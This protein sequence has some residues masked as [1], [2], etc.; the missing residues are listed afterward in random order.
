MCLSESCM[1]IICS[2]HDDEVSHCIVL[3][4][5]LSLNAKDGMR[6]K[7][8]GGGNW[9][10]TRRLAACFDPLDG[11]GNADAS[12]C[13]GTVVSFVSCICLTILPYID[14]LM[15]MFFSTYSLVSLMQML[16]LREVLLQT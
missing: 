15:I 11:S 4:L 12:I 9:G 1:H 7:T 13:T 5:L 8:D 14:C 10:N 3:L 16:G 6:K 2:I